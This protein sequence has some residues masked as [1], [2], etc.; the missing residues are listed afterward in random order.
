[1]KISDYIIQSISLL[2]RNP[3]YLFMLFV[4]IS[5]LFVLILSLL[6][7]FSYQSSIKKF[8]VNNPLIRMVSVDFTDAAIDRGKE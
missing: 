6:I 3:K 2:K 7:S 5:C 4:N 1:M 8:L